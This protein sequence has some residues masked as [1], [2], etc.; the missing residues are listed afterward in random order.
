MSFTV[1]EFEPTPN[2][3]ALKCRLDRRICAGTRSYL[4]PELGADDPVAG[5]LFAIDGVTAVM[6][7]QDFV[8]VNKAP[9][10]KWAAIKRRVKSTLASI[11][12]HE[13]EGGA[14]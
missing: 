8:T 7:C 11:D 13:F 4:R 6:L 10:A 9:D 14:F 2:P 3:N 12:G 1:V 5:P